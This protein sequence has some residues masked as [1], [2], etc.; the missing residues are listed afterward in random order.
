MWQ[1]WNQLK[2]SPSDIFTRMFL[3]HSYVSFMHFVN[4]SLQ[5]LSNPNQREYISS[6]WCSLSGL[7]RF[8]L[9]VLEVLGIPA[10]LEDPRGTGER[11]RLKNLSQI[12]SK[13][14]SSSSAVLPVSLSVLDPLL[15]LGYPDEQSSHQKTNTEHLRTEPQ[16][17]PPITGT[18]SKS[19]TIFTYQKDTLLP[20]LQLSPG[21]LRCQD[22]QLLQ[23]V[24][25]I[26]GSPLHPAEE[27]GV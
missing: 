24:R 18:T 12:R 16:G 4:L 2:L 1:I 7:S 20:F 11:D 14:S 19:F 17:C 9:A 27:G 22:N 3:I 8:L 21:D 6:H 15:V 13:S 25:H 26:P 23:G 10:V 5:S